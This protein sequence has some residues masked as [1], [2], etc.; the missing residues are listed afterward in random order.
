MFVAL[1]HTLCGE[2]TQNSQKL[3]VSMLKFTLKYEIDFWQVLCRQKNIKFWKVPVVLL[4][5][6]FW[7]N[8][9]FC[10]MYLF[11]YYQKVY[12]LG[13]YGCSASRQ[14]TRWI[15]EVFISKIY[16]PQQLNTWWNHTLT[17]RTDASYNSEVLT[18]LENTLLCSKDYHSMWK[19]KNR[20][21][22]NT[23]RNNMIFEKITPASKIT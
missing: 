19:W 3:L 6:I 5:Q 14:Y 12:V 11:R 10:I 4:Y 20:S 8:F 23:T 17:N 15:D 13:T 18:C 2:K 7:K 22:Q 9:I 16:H 21:R 1:V